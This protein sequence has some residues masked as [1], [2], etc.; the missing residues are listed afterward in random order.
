[1]GV[2]LIPIMKKSVIAILFVLA[3]GSS[4]AAED[5]CLTFRSCYEKGRKMRAAGEKA[6]ALS[7]FSKACS[8]ET[9]KSLVALKYSVCSEMIRYSKEL[10]N[11]VTARTLFQNLCDNGVDNGCFFLGKLEEELGEL[12]KAMALMEPLCDSGFTN[13]HVSGYDGCDALENLKRK[14]DMIHPPP[15]KQPRANTIQIP[16]FVSI[17]MFIL[18]ALV[19]LIWATAIKIRK[20]ALQAALF[21][22]LGFAAYIFYES[23]VSPYAAIRIDLLL[24]FPAL[25]LNLVIFV[26]AIIQSKRLKTR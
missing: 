13:P 22:F 17:F 15:P 24:A 2:P 4:L 16:V 14:W 21:S 6:M 9:K 25:I 1:M 18:L 10:D 3:A 8:K 23:G 11:A 5:S 7:A 12:E 19:F 26:L 20:K